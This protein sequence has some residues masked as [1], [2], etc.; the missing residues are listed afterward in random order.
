MSRTS[1]HVPLCWTDLAQVPVVHLYTASAD[2][3]VTDSAARDLANA[4]A[5]ALGLGAADVIVA[6]VPVVSVVDGAGPTSDE[7]PAVII[8][9]HRRDPA[10]MAAAAAAAASALADSYGLDT[11]RV[12]AQW[13][14]S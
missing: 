13:C 4:V 8:H 7:W 10:A 5:G 14:C 1:W 9:G 2:R 6:V 3:D 12:W 11:L